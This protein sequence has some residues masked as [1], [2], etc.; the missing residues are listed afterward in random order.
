MPEESRS[1]ADV[2]KPADRLEGT[3]VSRARKRTGIATTFLLGAE[4]NVGLLDRAARVVVGAF[5]LALVFVGPE[6]PWGLVGIVPLLT[7]VTGACPIYRAFGVST[8]R[9]STPS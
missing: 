5:L 9:P 3:R 8:S 7:G 1:S 6:A 4:P 2:V